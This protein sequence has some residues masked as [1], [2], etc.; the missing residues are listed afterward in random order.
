VPPPPPPP[1]QEPAQ[2]IS[3]I[4]LPTFHADQVNAFNLPGRFRALRCGRRWGKTRFLSTVAADAVIKGC[5]IGWF[6]PDYRISQESFGELSDILDPVLT[7][8]NRSLGML[9][10][11]T[12]GK[13]E[14]WTLGNPR[15]GRS[16]KYHGVIIDEAAFADIDLMDVWQKAIRST[17][18]DFRGW[19]IAASNTNGIDPKNFFWQICNESEHGFVEYHAPSHSNPYLPRDELEL[20]ERTYHPLVYQQEIL[21]DFVDFRGIAFFSLDKWLVNDKPVEW[22]TICDWV[23]A[24]VDT[25]IKSGQE[26]DGTAVTYY[27]LLQYPEPQLVILDWD[28]V[29]ID[30]AFLDSW[31]PNVFRR[32]DEFTRQFRVR[33]GAGKVFIEDKGSGTMLLQSGEA[34]GWPVH[35]IDSELTAKGKDERAIAVSGFHYSSRCKISGPAYDKTVQWH[36]HTLNHFVSQ[37]TGFRIGDKDAAKRADDLLDTYAYGLSIG[38]GGA[39]GF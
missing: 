23:F 18:L 32:L 1:P 35:A 6:A 8:T 36:G 34:R 25:A 3:K 7:S 24:V 27:A 14:V 21:A 20:F 17:L 11:R 38:L 19:C 22:P 15:A 31:V 26:H 37:V 28:I 13:I 9:E 2:H 5:S 16:R 10:A 33:Y 4:R 39:E 29:S 30:G 12:K